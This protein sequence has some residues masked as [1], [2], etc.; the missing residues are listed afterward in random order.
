MNTFRKPKRYGCE[1]ETSLRGKSQ[2]KLPSQFMRDM[3][4]PCKASRYY[5]GR[6]RLITNAPSSAPLPYFQGVLMCHTSDLH[7]EE[8]QMVPLVYLTLISQ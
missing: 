5:Y 2:C 8:T 6:L 7:V 4:A 1:S 3:G